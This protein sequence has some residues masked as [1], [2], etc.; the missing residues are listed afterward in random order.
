MILRRLGNKRKIKE[1]LAGHFPIHKFRI[2]LF[3]GAGGSF[4]NLP[5]PKYSLLNDLDDD[6]TNLYTT[7][8][9]EKEKLTKEIL[10]M[11]ICA[12][13]LKYWIKTKETDPVKKSVRFLFI[14]NFTY[15]GKGNTLRLSIDNTKKIMI[16]SIEPIFLMLQHSLITNEDFRNVIPKISFSKNVLSKDEAFIYLDPVYLDTIHNYKVPKWTKDD[17]EDCFRIMKNEGIK[18]AMSEFDHPY[19]L[20][21]ANKYNMNVITIKNRRNI[22]NRSTEILITNYKIAQTKL[23]LK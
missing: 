19:I 6:I 21:L 7:I 18:A 14:S 12:S 3:F 11:P 22:K 23:F 10:K 2:E 20:K 15:L 16:N 17:S 1:N 9:N 5:I 4:F 13:L 8:L